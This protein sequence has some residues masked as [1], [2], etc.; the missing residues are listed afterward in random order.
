MKKLMITCLICSVFFVPDSS[1]QEGK[2]RVAPR[3]KDYQTE[4]GLSDIQI[5]KMMEIQD[6]FIAKI[7]DARKLSPPD[8]DALR[9]LLEERRTK[10]EALL[11]AEQVAMWKVIV[12]SH[13]KNLPDQDLRKEIIKYKQENI[14]PVMIEKR[15]QFDKEL[16][17]EEKLVIAGLRAKH[18]A[19]RKSMK[20]FENRT[21]VK[22]RMELWREESKCALLPVIEKHKASL[23]NIA[24]EL[25]KEQEK[26]RDDPD[27]I[28]EANG[29]KVKPGLKGPGRNPVRFLLLPVE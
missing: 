25:K 20:N 1:A 6:E 14:L 3:L 22:E 2:K 8:R 4:L 21:D 10:L 23:D 13:H 5:K 17:E 27:R 29:M 15:R 12:K 26:W 11:T 9:R 28:R 19:L 18:D 7:K 24:R 16:T